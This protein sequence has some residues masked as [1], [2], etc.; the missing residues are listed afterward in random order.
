MFTTLSIVLLNTGIK[1]FLTG[2]GVGLIGFIFYSIANAGLKKA[3]KVLNPQESIH[4]TTD[5]GKLE[6]NAKL[7][8]QEGRR[9]EAIICLERILEVDAN[10]F[11]PIL[12]LGSLYFDKDNE[13]S[14]TFLKQSYEG[15]K[16]D[17]LDLT[18][19]D[20]SRGARN[21]YML[22]YHYNKKQDNERAQ[23]CKSLALKNKDFAKEYRDFIQRFAY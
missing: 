3:D 11:F 20:Y 6:Y 17:N 2:A 14:F 7:M 9:D 23:E 12:E 15:M 4:E 13:K 16:K 22:G 10:Q 8:L 18:N 21:V 5:L 19:N 1:V